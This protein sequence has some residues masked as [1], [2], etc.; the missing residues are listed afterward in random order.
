MSIHITPHK[1]GGWQV[2]SGNAK[3][4]FRV[5]D[6]QQEAIVIARQVA[7]HQDTDIKIHGKDG[8]VREG[9][10][11]ADKPTKSETKKKAKKTK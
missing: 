11:Y 1:N 2:L 10:N 7:I 9:R 3:K 4:P 5:V 8:K 6:T